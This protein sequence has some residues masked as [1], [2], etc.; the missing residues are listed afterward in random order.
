M[1]ADALKEQLVT[2]LT[3]TLE[4]KGDITPETPFTELELDSLVLLEFSV[5]LGQHYSVEI[6]EED[7]LDAGDV[8]AVASLVLARQDSATPRV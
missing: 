1:T 3:D 7:L 2:L 6:P 5:L 8:A 4:V